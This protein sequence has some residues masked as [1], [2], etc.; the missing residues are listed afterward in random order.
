MQQF[1]LP[2][3]FCLLLSIHT[4]IAQHYPQLIQTPMLLQPFLAGR[5]TQSVAVAGQVIDLKRNRH[6][7]GN[8]YFNY[9]LQNTNFFVSFDTKLKNYWAL[10]AFLVYEAEKYH[11][12]YR[13]YSSHE[14]DSSQSERKSAMLKSSVFLSKNFV[15]K[16]GRYTWS[17]IVGIDYSHQ[18]LS[19][20]Y[21]DAYHYHPYTNDTITITTAYYSNSSESQLNRT[22]TWA[23]LGM[24]TKRFVLFT[25][26]GLGMDM[27][28]VN[29]DS[30]TAVPLFVSAS[31]THANRHYNRAVCANQVSAQINF[32]KKE[33]TFFRFSPMVVIGTTVRLGN[34]RNNSQRYANVSDMN[35]TNNISANFRMWHVLFG[36]GLT[37]NIAG[38]YIGYAHQKSSIN[39]GIGEASFSLSLKQSF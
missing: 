35:W 25:R 20:D 1:S 29:Y 12:N 3:L 4:A 2:L 24:Q 10:G 15:S 14:Y 26:S 39:L 23:G 27:I 16:S 32:P 37:N 9:R 33:H 13:Y 17:P 6:G 8:D 5:D 22:L 31:E 38:F 28:K 18:N 34:Q 21:H 11:N 30:H 19:R 7:R 36:T